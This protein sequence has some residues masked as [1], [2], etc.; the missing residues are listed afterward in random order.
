MRTLVL[1]SHIQGPS[2]AHCSRSCSS[3]R[4]GSHRIVAKA[5][6]AQQKITTQEKENLQE[7]TARLEAKGNGTKSSE[8]P[9][10]FEVDAVLA[11]ELHDNGIS[12][13]S[14]DAFYNQPPPLKTSSQGSSLL[15]MLHCC[16]SLAERL[17]H[18]VVTCEDCEGNRGFKP[19]EWSRFQ[20]HKAHQDNMHHWARE[21]QPRDA[22]DPGRARHECGTLEYGPRHPGLAQERY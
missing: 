7:P 9:K 13:I 18:K 12:F 17:A 6:T 22:T 15:R 21:Q 11:K 19:C 1:G 4:I 10:D 5:S 14:N 3:G 2:N 16:L 20:K 8:G